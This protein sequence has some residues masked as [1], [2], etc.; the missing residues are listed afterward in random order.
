[1]GE[2]WRRIGQPVLPYP[3]ARSF[4]FTITIANVAIQEVVLW[5]RC[6]VE[7]DSQCCHIPLPGTSILPLQLL[8]LRYRGCIVGEVWRRIG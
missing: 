2:V 7:L 4:H 6:G 3:V 5:G 1:M 8:M